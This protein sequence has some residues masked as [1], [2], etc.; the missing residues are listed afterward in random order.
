M[1]LFFPLEVYL[2]LLLPL[3]GQGEECESGEREGPPAGPV[4]D[5]VP[6]LWVNVHYL[7]FH[8]VLHRRMG[9]FSFGVEGDAQKIRKAGDVTVLKN[10]ERGVIK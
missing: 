8:C 4:L 6:D 10:R 3:Q 5:V 1:L 2:I 9:V 7:F